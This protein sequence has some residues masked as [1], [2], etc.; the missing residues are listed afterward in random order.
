MRKKILLALA[1]LILIACAPTPAVAPTIVPPSAAPLTPNTPPTQS[2]SAP[3]PISQSPNLASPTRVI[4]IGFDDWSMADIQTKM[5][6]LWAFMQKGAVDVTSH[7]S[8]L[9]QRSAPGFASIASGQYPDHHGVINNSFIANQPR[10][11]FAYWDNLAKRTPPTLIS[12]SPWVAFNRAGWDVGAIGWNGLALEERADVNAYLGLDVGND[13]DQYWGIAIHRKDGRAQFGAAEI[14]ELHAEFADGWKNGWAGPPRKSASVTLPMATA[15][16]KAGV[17]FVFV[18]VE[19]THGRC[20]ATPQSCQSDLANGTFD[21]LL[22]ADDAAFGKFFSDLTNLNITLDNTLFVFTT[23]EQDHYLANYAQIVDT[24]DLQPAIAGSGA[25]LFYGPD[26]DAIGATLVA[27]KGVQFIATREA[28]KALHIVNGAD[29]RTPTIVAFSDADYYFNRGACAA[30]GRWNHATVHPDI[31]SWL[32]LVGPGIKRGAIDGY[33]DHTDIIPTIRA[34]LGISSVLD[35]DGLPIFSAF[36]RATSTDLLQAR[37]EH[38]QLNAP[39]GKFGLA[40][41]KISTEGVRGGPAARAVAD[42][43]IAQLAAR[44]DALIAELRPALDGAKQFSPDQ[45][46]DLLKRAQMLIEEAGK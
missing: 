15:M 20:G 18:Y 13:L 6:N 25:G 26:T 5:P 40:I 32:A 3:S 39:L 38:K 36:D 8:D 33:S 16:L 34:A 45:I 11:G 14:P 12:E 41:L 4:V 46:A 22:Q 30:C 44:R 2:V 10:T 28:I 43:R 7:H 31:I 29:A 37:E 27:R 17:P 19:N 9:P 24:T 42:A 35:V 23:D 21:D 1:V